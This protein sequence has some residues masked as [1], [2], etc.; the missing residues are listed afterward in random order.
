MSMAGSDV[1]A[2]I[3]QCTREELQRRKRE[4]SADELAAQ[5]ERLAHDRG[6]RARGFR[7]AISQPP[8]AVIAEF[9]RRSP[10]AG[11][12][13]EQAD[14]P[15]VVRAYEQGGASALSVLTERQHFD[16]SLEDLRLARD[17]S[18]LPV[19]RKD[20]IVDPYQLHE[21]VIAG[22]DALLLIAA[23]L[24]PAELDELHAQARELELDVLVEVHDHDELA[25]ALAVGAELV[26]IN[27]RDL[28]DFSVDLRRTAELVREIPAEVC[29]V[30]ESGID[31]AEQLRLLGAEG[32]HAVLI[33]EALMR[34]PDPRAALREL[35][36]APAAAS[37]PSKI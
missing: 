6:F 27:N 12:L 33:G 2:R 29:V 5:A 19:L 20:F 22:A 17:N 34:S 15:A 9:K 31:R 37:E 8:I 32:V 3:V 4:R 7:D 14:L 30:S 16:G 35:L 26:G 11:T 28:R 23:A 18:A 21:T 25:T 10:S 13:R 36:G 24:A 1:L